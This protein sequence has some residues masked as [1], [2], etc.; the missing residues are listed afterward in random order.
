[1]DSGDTEFQSRALDFILCFGPA[2]LQ[3]SEVRGIPRLSY[4]S[5]H[6]LPSS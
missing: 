5:K 3:S 1:V 4:E 2:V 6:L